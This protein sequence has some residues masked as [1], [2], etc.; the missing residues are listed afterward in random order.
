[1]LIPLGHEKTTVRRVPWVT[2]TIM[3]VCVVVFILGLPG[4]LRQQ[5]DSAIRIHHAIGYFTQ[6]PYLGMSPR[7]AEVF[8][9]E[10]GEEQA[11]AFA[12]FLQRSGLTPPNDERR[13]AW[14]QKKLDVITAAYF[15][16]LESSLL[17]RFGLVPAN[18]NPLNVVTYQ[19]FHV[20]WI[21]L[22]FNLLFLFLTGPFIEDVWG[23]PLFATF[24][25]AGGAFA[26]LMFAIRFPEVQTPLVGASG[27]IAA[28]MGAFLV[29]FLKSKIRFILWIF[30]PLGPFSAP[31]WVIFPLWFGIQ[32]RGA[33]TPGSGDG[34]GG[35][36]AH[37]WGFAFGVIFAYVMVHYR[38]EDRWIDEAIESKVSVVD[39]ADVDRALLLAETGNPEAAQS[40]LERELRKRPGDV[41]AAMA[42]WNLSIKEG[43]GKRALPHIV[44]CIEAAIR[45]GDLQFAMNH[46]ENILELDPQELEIDS[47]LAVRVAEI[48]EADRRL[49]PALQTLQLAHR[50]ADEQTPV[51]VILKIARLALLLD[52]P[53]SLTLVDAALN[54]PRIP[55]EA[56]PELEVARWALARRESDPEDVA[57]EHEGGGDEDLRYLQVTV[58]IPIA[59]NDRMLSV[60]VRGAHRQVVFE[61][62]KAVAVAGIA[63]EGRRPVA[64]IDLL[65]DHPG[66]EILDPRTIRL[67][68]DSFDSRNMVGG[69]DPRKAFRSFLSLLIDSSQAEALPDLDA[70]RAN[71]F[72]SYPSLEAYELEVFG[73]AS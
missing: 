17:Y 56:K 18:V 32:L 24:Y 65:L 59:V 20:G 6:H 8:Q 55:P 31:A 33:L 27:A 41:D 25:L 21:H 29:R 51:G 40:A 15:Q 70:A 47:M 73:V 53:D 69:D 68:G 46:W 71:P 35:F 26:G 45:S 3:A 11:V 58:A 61:T 57:E 63:R 39:N 37:V 19:F 4:E 22:I 48:L 42:L 54:H 43:E 50:N 1:M 2:F 64:V 23:R 66:S 13:L 7:F 28:V 9:R 52:A 60:D 14:E 36:W 62:V 72:R 10:L 67:F 34:G 49:D 12:E 5:V 16:S 38:I 30:V 44:R